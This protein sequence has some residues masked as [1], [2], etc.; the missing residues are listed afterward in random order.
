MKRETLTFIR[1]L[2]SG[3]RCTLNASINREGDV[4]TDWEGEPPP[5]LEPVLEH[6]TWVLE[7][8]EHLATRWNMRL[9]HPLR[10]PPDVIE[11]W[12]FLPNVEAQRLGVFEQLG[13]EN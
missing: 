10:L 6:R 9:T 11:I 8:F 5:E 2:Q 3:D 12:E 7:T 13:E 1:I 4:T